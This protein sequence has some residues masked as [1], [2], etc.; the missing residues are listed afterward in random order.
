V[1]VDDLDALRTHRDGI[2]ERGSSILGYYG[3]GY[4]AAAPGQSVAS[5]RWQLAV[6]EDGTYRLQASWTEAPNRATRA[7][8]RL[9]QS[10]RQ[11]GEAEVDQQE[12]GGR[13]AALLEAPLVASAPCVVELEAAT[14]GVVV[15]DAVRLVQVNPP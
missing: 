4:Q 13:W 3:S 9:S 14:D 5:Y 7:V 2:W 12:P 10:G 1:I 8:Y 6:P 11:L 15:A